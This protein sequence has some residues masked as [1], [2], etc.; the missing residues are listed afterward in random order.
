[1]SYIKFNIKFNQ[2]GVA[3]YLTMVVLSLMTASLLGLAAALVGQSK[4]TSNLSNSIL[5]FSAADSGIEQALYKVYKEGFVSGNF[6]A[7]LSNGA[8]YSVIVSTT[9]P[10][11]STL[12]RSTGSYRK[13]KRAI[14]ATL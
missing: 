9:T 6:S 1:M 7:T 14:E 5:A 4:M 13:S 2:K 10:S 3:L 12:I 8:T 11:G